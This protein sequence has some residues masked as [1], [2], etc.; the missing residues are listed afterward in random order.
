MRLT[1]PETFPYSRHSSYA[2]LCYLI[3]AFRPEEIH[4]CTV[5]EASWTFS[6]S[7]EQCFG[8]LYPEAK[9]FRHDEQMLRRPRKT[10]PLRRLRRLS[11]HDTS[12]GQY[13]DLGKPRQP[14]PQGL[15]AAA[16]RPERPRDP[17]DALGTSSVHL[18]PEQRPNARQIDTP[19]GAGLEND[20]AI[21]RPSKQAR[22]SGRAVSAPELENSPLSL[23]QPSDNAAVADD[24]QTPGMLS[25]SPAVVRAAMQ[26][27]AYKAALARDGTAWSDIGLVSVSGH[28]CMEEEL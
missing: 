15:A 13:N 18:Q 3:E 22:M 27:E 21:H 14:S 2:E 20:P 19:E 17:L 28:T 24:Q 10:H 6:V 25:L 11:K 8:H 5:D 26:R 1:S 7:M 9:K 16:R 23:P 4:P 12:R